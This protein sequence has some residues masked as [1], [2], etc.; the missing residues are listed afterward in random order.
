MHAAMM[1]SSDST[2]GRGYSPAAL[3]KGEPRK[4][5]SGSSSIAMSKNAR[6]FASASGAF[7]ARSPQRARNC[8]S[9]C[10]R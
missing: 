9:S 4:S 6:I 1:R 10:S 8:S 5:L 2:S 7:A 3:R